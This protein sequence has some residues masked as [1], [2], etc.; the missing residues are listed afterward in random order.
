MNN[1]TRLLQVLLLSITFLIGCEN[2]LAEHVAVEEIKWKS[3]DNTL[4]DEAKEQNKLVFLEVGANW[5][6]WCHVM[7]DSTY[8]NEAVKKYLNTHFVLSRE[9][10][11]ARP[12]LFSAYKPWGWPAIIIFNAAGEELLKLK[13]FRPPKRFLKELKQI[14]E[15][16]V[17]LA[18][19]LDSHPSLV[20]E[21]METLN[22]EFETQLDYELGGYPHKNRALELSGIEHALRYRTDNN[23][24]EE[25]AKLTITQSY[26]LVD[27]T[28]SGVYQYSAKNSWNNQHFEK[29]LR[30]QAN[31]IETYCRYGVI[32]KD[33]EA[34]QKAE[35]IVA[36]CKRFLQG[37][38]PLFWNSQNADLIA[39]EHSGQ[40]YE[41]NEAERLKQGVPSV[42]Q[43][44]YLKENAAMINAMIWLWAATNKEEYLREGKEMLD[45]ALYT[46]STDRGIYAREE[47]SESI[48]SFEDNRQ[49]IES[50]LL[51]A[52]VTNDKTYLIKAEILA[53]N[54]ITEFDSKEG[55]QSVCGEITL[56]SPIVQRDNLA[57]KANAYDFIMS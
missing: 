33:A 37:E 18:F 55:I 44:I 15:N 28:W 38:T 12:D 17:P 42:D 3:F 30:Y 6:H 11:D 25:W 8:T 13:G 54:C 46:F 31:Y 48:F 29:L 9:D 36:Y 7:D 19:D 22:S 52:Q 1:A 51:Y 47:G 16:P 35:E 23:S 45:H 57:K 27:P 39:G 50:L 43:K 10:Q 4:F 53:K 49:L 24:L 20:S 26:L 14:V 41:L 40:Y 21:S 56:K 2:H 34:I 32:M 5:C